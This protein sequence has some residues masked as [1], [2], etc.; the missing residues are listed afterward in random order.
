MTSF[1]VKQAP[2]PGYMPTFKVQ[3]QIYHRI[4]SVHADRENYKFVVISA[5]RRPAAG[6][7]GRYNAPATNE[8]AVVLMD[9]EYDRRDVMLRTR[10][11]RLQR[12]S[13]THRAYDSLQYPLMFCRGEDGYN[14]A[15]HHVDPQPGAPYYTRI[16]SALQFYSYRLQL[17]QD[18]GPLAPFQRIETERLVYIRTHQRQLRAENYVDLRDALQRDTDAENLGRMS[19]LPSS[20]DRYMAERTQDALCYAR[21]Y[22]GADLFITFTCNPKW[23]EITNELLAVQLRT[24]RHDIVSRVFHLK[25]KLLID[26]LTKGKNRGLPRSQTLL[27]LEEKNWPNDID[28]AIIAELPDPEVDPRL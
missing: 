21:K 18:E 3:G 7:A 16:T 12:I 11:D 6:H 15:I 22:G 13:E 28:L 27:W 19:I 10:D 23:P 24:D 20:S 17:R 9:Q 8:V 4:E 26:L 1:G 25:R 2:E 14:F 5:D